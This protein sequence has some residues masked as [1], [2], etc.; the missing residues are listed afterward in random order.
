MEAD[1]CEYLLPEGVGAAGVT[2]ALAGHLRLEA[3]R[4]R[5]V[6]RTFYDT[7]DGLLRAAGLVLVHQDRRLV[8]LDAAQA[9]Q[10]VAD[11]PQRPKRLFA[12]DLPAG[13]LREL[14][15]PVLDVRAV[16]PIARTRSRLLP[17][18]VLDGQQ[19]TVVRLEVEEATALNGRVGAPLRPRLRAA[20]VRGYDKAL[21]RVR[22]TL[23]GDL[24]LATA[25]ES[26]RDEAVRAAG[27]TPAGISSKLQL[28][29]HPDQRADTAAVI[30]LTTLLATIQQ[31]LPGTLADVD[32]E[33]LHDLRVAVRRTRSA[34]RQ[35]R[36]VFPPGPVARFRA[37]FR[38]LQQVTGPTRDLDVHLLELDDAPE[39]DPLR[40]LLTARRA[41][42][43]RRMQRA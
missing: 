31:N 14:V 8:L 30:L 41:L 7:F 32:S 11:L 21:A 4:A 3:G 25:D 17:L 20:A 40:E 18:H 13:R 15:T 12:A 24:G 19:K 42:E 43:R 28:A 33:F 38:R 35:L 6:H 39:L 16:T 36:R 5:S 27:G 29:L 22:H 37:E 2:A 9:E 1:V 23:T 10:A 26:V 34:Q